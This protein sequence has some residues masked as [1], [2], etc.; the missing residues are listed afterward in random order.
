MIYSL[1]QQFSTGPE[2]P[3]GAQLRMNAVPGP[4][5]TKLWAS[6]QANDGMDTT[7]VWRSLALGD[8]VAIQDWDNAGT[9]AHLNVTGPVV[10]K[11][12][13][14]EVPV[15]WTTGVG[16]L[17]AQKVLVVLDEVEA[18][19]LPAGGAP[20]YVLAKTSAADYA[21]TWVE[22]ASGNV[23]PVP[24]APLPPLCTL[25]DL[26]ALGITGDPDDLNRLID[27][28]SAAARAW[29]GWVI[30]PRQNNVPL[31]GR[32]SGKVVTLPSLWLIT[33]HGVTV[34]GA[35]VPVPPYMEAGVLQL[36]VGPFNRTIATVDHGYETIPPDVAMN[37]AGMVARTVSAPAGV[38][39]ERVGMWS[40]SYTRGS[41]A[42]DESAAGGLAPYALPIVP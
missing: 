10:D 15:A 25:D 27:A 36:Q 2:P 30:A 39:G 42:V 35:D 1:E 26:K 19:G 7:V 5:V 37:V 33:V 14:A 17:P 12:G 28:A 41:I 34:D 11:G 3:T 8:K 9:N 16:T 22:P 6:Y 32:Y 20:G 38:T 13:Y 24:G 4:A 21:A 40:V 29:C 18:P 31:L 23:T